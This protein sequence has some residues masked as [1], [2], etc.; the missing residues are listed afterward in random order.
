[1]LYALRTIIQLP[2]FVARGAGDDGSDGDAATVT[3]VGLLVANGIAFVIG[4]SSNCIAAANA[5]SSFSLLVTRFVVS[6]Q[7]Q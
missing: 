3:V 6:T 5:K 1:M 4:V 7:R 2:S